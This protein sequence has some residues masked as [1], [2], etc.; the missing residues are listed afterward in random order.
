LATTKETARGFYAPQNCS[1]NQA[2][3]EI[4]FDK[5]VFFADILALSDGRISQL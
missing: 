1:L 4:Y 5:R 2:S 3:Y